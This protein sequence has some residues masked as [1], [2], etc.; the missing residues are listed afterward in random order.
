LLLGPPGAVLGAALGAVL[1][2]EQD[3]DNG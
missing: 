2:H 3:P 1:G